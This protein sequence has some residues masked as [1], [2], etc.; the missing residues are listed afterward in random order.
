MKRGLICLKNSV[1]NFLTRLPIAKFAAADV[2]TMS[3]Q[4]KESEDFRVKFEKFAFESATAVY[5]PHVS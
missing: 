2:A 3:K 1:I 5:D 4:L